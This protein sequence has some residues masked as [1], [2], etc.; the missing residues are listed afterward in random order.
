MLAVNENVTTLLLVVAAACV[1]AVLA[2][3]P[4]HALR[5]AVPDVPNP[6]PLVK[7]TAVTLAAVTDG[8]SGLGPYALKP[9]N[10]NLTRSVCP[11]IFVLI[12]V[13]S[14]T[15]SAAI[16]FLTEIIGLFFCSVFRFILFV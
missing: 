7:P 15:N 14:T 5:P 4:P 12:S 11:I 2:A 13:M 10:E 6:L 3:E 9:L 1:A 16:L 8:V